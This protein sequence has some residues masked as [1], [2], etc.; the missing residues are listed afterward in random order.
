MVGFWDRV[1]LCNSPGCPGTHSVDQAGLKLRFTCWV[2]WMLGLKMWATTAQPKFIIFLAGQLPEPV[3][4]MEFILLVFT[5]KI[6]PQHLRR[7]YWPGHSLCWTIYHTHK[8]MQWEPGFCFE[9]KHRSLSCP[10]PLPYPLSQWVGTFRCTRTC[11]SKSSRVL[12]MV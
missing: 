6:V 1:S 12:T 10:L 11:D 7:P 8:S 3:W 5:S 4:G 2:S 9:T